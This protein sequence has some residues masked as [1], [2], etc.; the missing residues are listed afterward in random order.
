[1]S[2][3][4][5]VHCPACNQNVIAIA[6]T[7]YDPIHLCCCIFFPIIGWIFCLMSIRTRAPWYEWRSDG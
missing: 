6:R 1:M 2:G 5:M 7:G 4:A 3:G